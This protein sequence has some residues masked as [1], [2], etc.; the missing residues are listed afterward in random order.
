M[1]DAP[2][3]QPEPRTASASG[4]AQ[5]TRAAI[6]NALTIARVILAILC[7]V[8]I[9]VAE[10]RVPEVAGDA[11]TDPAATI[12]PSFQ[13]SPW[14]I[15]ALALF[16]LAAV[17]DAL[18]G[19]LARKWQVVSRFGRVMDPFADKL[20]I[21][22]TFIML[23]DPVFWSGMTVPIGTPLGPI[24]LAGIQPWMAVAI[25]ARELLVTS[26]RGVY[27]S[28]GVDFSATFSGKVK[29]VLQCIAAPI[30]MLV[31]VTQPTPVPRGIAGGLAGVIW[32]TV[33]ATLLSGLPYG[34]RALRTPR[35]PVR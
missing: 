11:A 12:Y 8:C 31:L 14:I 20:L 19:H 17:T 22:G 34:I 4:S 25:L 16:V 1:P 6:P 32:L 9:G 2:S 3:S 33:I 7:F 24:N 10:P 18:D 30:A 21:L 15:G 27:E 29:M 23:A 26:L 35:G 5:R 13:G 28:D